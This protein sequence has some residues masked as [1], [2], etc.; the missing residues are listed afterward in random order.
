M[1]T[2]AYCYFG[3]I[4]RALTFLKQLFLEIK[5][6]LY[7][8]SFFAYR[9]RFPET[10]ITWSNLLAA[11]FYDQDKM[12]CGCNFSSVITGHIKSLCEDGEWSRVDEELRLFIL[13]QHTNIVS[14]SK[15]IYGFL[16]RRIAIKRN[17]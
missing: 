6:F 1:L 3:E 4:S 12:S 13:L 10:E 9:P 17:K 8:D 14:F 16:F 2:L 11:N 5:D 15:N 7:K